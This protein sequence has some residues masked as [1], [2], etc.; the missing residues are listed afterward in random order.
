[1]HKIEA[2]IR[3]EMDAI[4]GQEVTLPFVHP[5]DLWRATGRWFKIGAEMSR[6]QDR[7]QRDLLL[8]MTHEEVVAD[9]ARREIQ[10]YRQLPRLVYQ[11][12]T[13]WRDEPRPR[14]GLIR[15]REFTMKDSYSLDADWN[16]LERQ[17]RAHFQAYFNIFH[18]CGLDVIA[19]ESDTGMMGGRL[20]HEFMALNPV[21]EDTLLIC[22]ACG[23]AANRQVARFT[24]ARYPGGDPAPL[25]KV[26][27]PDCKTIE[28]VADY[29]GVPTQMTAK[30]VFMTATIA[31]GQEISERLVFAVVRGD[32]EV[33]ETKLANAVSALELR[34]ATEA[35]ILAVGA[36]PGYASPVGLRD[37]LIVVDELIPAST[38]LV[39]GANESGYHFRNVNYGRDF[40]AHIVADLTAARQ[41][42]PCP[43]CQ[44]AL[45]A[46]RGVEVGNIFQLGDFYSR[47]LGV[48]YLDENRQEQPVIM[49]SYGIGVTRL[50]AV[51]AETCND[52]A[53]LRWPVSVAPYHIHLV[54]LS[55]KDDPRPAEI[56]ETVYQELNGAGL[57]TLFDDR[58]D[59]PGVKFN[60]ADLIG[61][62]LRLT[63]SARSL[64]N[65]GVEFK[66]RSQEA[67]SI[68]ALEEVIPAAR[69]AL[70]SLQ[71]EINNRLKAV[72]YP[73]S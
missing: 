51:I 16:G 28:A 70:E 45:R 58:D 59:S 57:E 34:P 73:A 41:G 32:M 18:R 64:K 14:G 63:V 37:A 65:G 66:L 12:Q 56:A 3:E 4:G 71:A 47:A 7:G 44:A 23:Y 49:G 21:G 39:S 40:Q 72:D 24:R 55:G 6:F 22:E 67:R 20:A 9:L 11:I 36:V 61:L 33:N 42:D 8:A 29:L 30:A 13:K 5:A 1:M 25:E 15:G 2:I 53:G 69:A 38:N 26:A 68:L 54:L 10:S 19:V 31:A 17:Y 62:P 60:D 46:E 27:T 43:R 48:T 35:E 50:V 52:S